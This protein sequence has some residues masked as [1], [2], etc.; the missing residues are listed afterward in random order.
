MKK[1]F[2]EIEVETEVK[3]LERFEAEYDNYAADCK[4]ALRIALTNIRNLEERLDRAEYYNPFTDATIDS[5][6]KTFKSAKNKCTERGYETSIDGIKNNM[7]DIAGIRI[8]VQYV[9]D[10]QAV[11]D[12]L[13]LTQGINIVEIKDYVK[14]PKENGYSGVH[15]ICQVQ[16]S[17]L[18]GGSQ[19]IPIEIQIRTHAMNLWAE[20]EHM[21]KYKSPV[22]V[23]SADA[24]FKVAAEF[25]KNF[26]QK[27][28]EMRRI[29]ADATNA[30]I[31]DKITAE[32]TAEVEEI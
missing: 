10:I 16:I 11:V 2:D 27:M 20:Y 9:D 32:V 24:N 28:T 31:T 19:L 25:V 14:K 1:D 29:L 18:R 6:I 12:M 30:T 5:R 23:P 17:N 26:D 22:P 15:L 21:F 8:V 7:K 13:Q 3:G 4:A